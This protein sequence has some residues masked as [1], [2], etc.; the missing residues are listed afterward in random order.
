LSCY[1]AVNTTEKLLHYRVLN[2]K[3]S[4]VSGL[5]LKAKDLGSNWKLDFTFQQR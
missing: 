1:T 2:K 4:S 3:K 5:E